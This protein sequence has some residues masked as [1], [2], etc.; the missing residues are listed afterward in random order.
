MRW[1][2]IRAIA[3]SI[4]LAFGAGIPSPSV[5]EFFK[6]KDENGVTRFTDNLADVPED[7]LEA[8]Q[9]YKEADDFLTPQQRE[10]KRRKR[11]A[12]M[13][14]SRTSARKKNEQRKLNEAGIKE[15]LAREAKKTGIDQKTADLDKK[16]AELKK[17]GME[18][19]TRRNTARA[20]DDGTMQV[21]LK[22]E[23]KEHDK[24][25]KAYKKKRK[26]LDDEIQQFDQDQET[27]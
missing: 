23:K 26:E 1:C 20:M 5:A 10:E 21:I 27:Q 3:F 7:Q 25:V 6:Y 11:D 2:M 18:I 15:K 4:V 17:A 8:V 16:K 19:K 22:N 14:S 9:G 12:D 24:K 13:Q